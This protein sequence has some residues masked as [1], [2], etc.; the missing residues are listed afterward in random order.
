MWLSSSDNFFM[1]SKN[2]IIRNFEN[3]AGPGLIQVLLCR[4]TFRSTA[5][6]QSG[7]IMSASSDRKD[8]LFADY[9][10]SIQFQWSNLK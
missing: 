8:H 10:I 1:H 6:T 3:E 7:Y 9:L 2:K 5:L 4:K